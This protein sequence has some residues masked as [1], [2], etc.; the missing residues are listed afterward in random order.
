[1]LNW[2]RLQE[3]KFAHDKTLHMAQ[4]RTYVQRFNLNL[5]SVRVQECVK[6]LTTVGI[7]ESPVKRRLP[8]SEVERAF[9]VVRSNPEQR[10]KLEHGEE[11]DEIETDVGKEVRHGVPADLF[12]NLTFVSNYYDY[13][14]IFSI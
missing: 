3:P 13:N 8:E 12:R 4:L 11:V 5:I 10:R 9:S 14:D 7:P 1:M 6:T 2:R